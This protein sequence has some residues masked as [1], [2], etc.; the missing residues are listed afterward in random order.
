MEHLGAFSSPGD[1]A[2]PSLP[3]TLT[4]P[5]VCRRGNFGQGLLR[6]AKEMLCKLRWR[7]R[8]TNPHLG[9]GEP[10]RKEL[11]SVVTT[12]SA[13]AWGFY[14]LQCPTHPPRPPMFSVHGVGGSHGPWTLRV[15]ASLGPPVHLGY[16]SPTPSFSWEIY[17][18]DPT[19][20]WLPCTVLALSQLS[21]WKIIVSLAS[22]HF[23][24]SRH[25]NYFPSN[26]ITV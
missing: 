11:R 6:E 1:G 16:L 14:R 17:Y 10:G 4:A 9:E 18:L 7:L 15:G 25:S 19:P 5:F 21:P 2:P 8:S 12:A 23:L 24:S 22:P 20:R 3:L 13:S 26:A